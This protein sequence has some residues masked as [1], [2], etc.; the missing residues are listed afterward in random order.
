MEQLPDVKA[1][2]AAIV[3]VRGQRVM[4][5]ADLARLYGVETRRLNQQ[6]RRNPERFPSDFMFEL[7]LSE[8]QGMRLQN[9]SSLRCSNTRNVAPLAFTEHGC[10]MLANVLRSGRAVE[11][12][13]LI[14]RAFVQMRAAAVTNAVLAARVGA[15]TQELGRHGEK[16]VTH[17]EAILRI[18]DEIRRLTEF[19]DEPR[20]GIGFTAAWPDERGASEDAGL[21]ATPPDT[22]PA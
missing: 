8:W 15:L 7:S 4:L 10:L 18:L 13:V 22:H 2:G 1:I 6:V 14:V 5:D 19:P 20:R 16:L 17:D 11:V 12:S 9:A 3:V 21:Q